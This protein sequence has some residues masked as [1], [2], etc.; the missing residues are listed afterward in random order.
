M[1]NVVT[2]RTQAGQ[3]AAVL[4]ADAQPGDLVVYCPDQLGPAVHRLVPPGL[5]EVDVSRRSGR[6]AFVDWVDYT[7]RLARA[8]PQAFAREALARAGNHTLWFVTSP[9]YITHPVVCETLSTL[10]AAA[11]RRQ[12]RVGPDERIFEHPGPA[13]VP[14]RRAGER[15]ID[16]AVTAR[17]SFG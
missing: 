6:P 13:G 3:V 8:D 9:G 4:R 2:N 16:G 5:D 7:T 10:F 1:R 15:L 17:R 11:R 14:G 12:V